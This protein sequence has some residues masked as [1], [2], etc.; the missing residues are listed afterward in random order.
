M[1]TTYNTGNDLIPAKL[2]EKWRNRAINAERGFADL[3]NYNG[4]LKEIAQMWSDMAFKM[5][6]QNDAYDTYLGNIA[7]SLIRSYVDSLG[8]F[9]NKQATMDITQE[10]V[11]EHNETKTDIVELADFPYVI[12]Q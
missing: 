10:A 6:A 7:F 9:S 1:D 5:Q 11:K 4:Q 12:H 2:Y 8:I 3:L